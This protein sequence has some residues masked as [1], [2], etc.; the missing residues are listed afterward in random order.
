MRRALL[1]GAAA[2]ACAGAIAAGA[3]GLGGGTT[4][5]PT[6]P[7][8]VEPVLRQTLTRTEPVNGVLG[9]GTTVPVPGAGQG[10]ITWLPAPAA[11]LRRGRAVFRADDRPVPL[12]Y[13]PLP[14]YRTL[15]PGL[16]GRDVRLVERNLWA[17]G[18]R[19]FTVDGHFSTATS[20]A[21]RA[22]QRKLHLPR[23]GVV[24]PSSLVVTPGPV[25]VAA[26][27]AHL[28]DPASGPVL[29]YSGT[30][31]V[32]TVALDV[33]LQDLARRGSAAVIT[34]PDGRTVRG[35]VA[36]VGRVASAAHQEGG[37]STIAV[38]VTTRDQKALGRFDQAPVV[39]GLRG[40]SAK[41][42]LTVPV[43]ALLA[44]PGGGYAVRVGIRQVPV[45]VGLFADGRVEVRG[46]AAGTLVGVPS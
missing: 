30:R 26:V 24:E 23:T 12:F 33:A 7:Q 6:A 15:R 27:S 39:V 2:L 10:T 19:G 16:S 29:T 18:Y 9:Y 38:T 36:T 37:P 25:R 31:R 3:A 22:W 44:R 20:T 21:V 5:P 40:A 4:V 35:R 1:L 28:G 41:N 8:A 14:L 11:V 42:V 32:V 43:T 34:L 45:E 17:L 13:G 46:V